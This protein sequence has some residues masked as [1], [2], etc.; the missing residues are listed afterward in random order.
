MLVGA[1]LFAVVA[2]AMMLAPLPS[3]SN[4]HRG[5]LSRNMPG[6]SIEIEAI[7][8]SP[9]CTATTGMPL[10]SVTLAEA[11]RSVGMSPI[12]EQAARTVAAAV[13]PSAAKMVLK[14]MA[15]PFDCGFP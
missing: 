5:M 14:V 8:T 12:V 7:G 6:T 15:V 11:T 1:G 9:V 13:R 4:S 3:S 10:E 2:V